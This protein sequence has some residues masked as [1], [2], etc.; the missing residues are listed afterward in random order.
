MLINDIND[1]FIFRFKLN[2]GGRKIDRTMV[3]LITDEMILSLHL[4]RGL[5]H[6]PERVFQSKT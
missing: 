6:V 3:F 2:D 1:F 4:V 5:N